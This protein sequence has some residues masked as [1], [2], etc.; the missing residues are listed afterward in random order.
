M[1]INNMFLW[2]SM[3]FCLLSF[4]QTLSIFERMMGMAWTTEHV[5]FLIFCTTVT[6]DIVYDIKILNVTVTSKS[7]CWLSINNLGECE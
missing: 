5:P 6:S 2:Q 3:S 1:G 4:Q 7:M